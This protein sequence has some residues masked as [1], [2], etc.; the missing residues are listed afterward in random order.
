MKVWGDMSHVSVTSFNKII[1]SNGAVKTKVEVN[2]GETKIVA[3]PLEHAQWK[4]EFAITLFP[5]IFYSFG[6]VCY[7][8]LLQAETTFFQGTH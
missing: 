8:I 7:K 5:P 1:S 4:T 2:L 6:N 3:H